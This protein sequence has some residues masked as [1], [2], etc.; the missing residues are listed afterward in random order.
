MFSCLERSMFRNN[1]AI[2]VGFT[3]VSFN[4]LDSIRELLMDDYFEG[5]NKSWLQSHSAALGFI[6]YSQSRFTICFRFL[7]HLHVDVFNNAA[8][9]T[10]MVS[11]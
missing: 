2:G 3:N 7:D 10:A 4:G 9:L 8:I 5:A 6:T 1:V 11:I